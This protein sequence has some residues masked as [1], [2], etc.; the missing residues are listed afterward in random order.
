[1]R[2][3]H[4]AEPK[5]DS[6]QQLTASRPEFVA[7]LRATADRRVGEGLDKWLLLYAGEPSLHQAI[8]V[9]QDAYQILKDPVNWCTGDDG[10]NQD[11][12]PV[13]PNDPACVQ[14][15]LGGAMSLAELTG[16]PYGR[17]VSCATSQLA[18]VT[19]RW[20]I[21]G[22][23][24]AYNDAAERKHEEI[25]AVLQQSIA[26]LQEAVDSPEYDSRNAAL[27]LSSC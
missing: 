3:H 23:I 19:I 6:Q 25:L 9:L 17:R 16:S 4:Y 20:L 18:Q 8:G 24:P 22:P 26:V 14:R 2:T 10:L 27:T 5:H 7:A 11:G 12:F 15:C 1:M 13:M 21:G